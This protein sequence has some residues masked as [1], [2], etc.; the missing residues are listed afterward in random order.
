MFILKDYLA[1][2]S[3]QDFHT[4]LK[5]METIGCLEVRKPVQKHMVCFGKWSAVMYTMGAL[6]LMG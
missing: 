2:E 4:P 6:H 5:P 3:L 1:Q